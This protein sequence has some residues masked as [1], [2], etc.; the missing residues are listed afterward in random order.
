MR[1]EGGGLGWGAR[2]GA[3]ERIGVKVRVSA[4]WGGGG[5][6]EGGA[7]STLRCRQSL[8]VLRQSVSITGACSGSGARAVCV[9]RAHAVSYCTMF[10]RTRLA[11]AAQVVPR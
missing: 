9:R 2:L 8:H 3:R 1:G 4:A 11:A 10:Y 7:A 5:E 6:G